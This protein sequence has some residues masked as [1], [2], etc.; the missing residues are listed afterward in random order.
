[1]NRKFLAVAVAT[2]S[3]SGIAAEWQVDV[4]TGND[5]AAAVDNTGATRFK[6]IQAA[7][8]KA[9]E[10]DVVRVHPGVYDSG[11]CVSRVEDGG[12][13][14]LSNRVWI[15]KKIT[16]V[17]VAGRDKTFI[18]GHHDPNGWNGMGPASVRCIGLG[19]NAEGTVV[20]GFTLKDGAT[21]LHSSEGKARAG[22]GVY[23]YKDYARGNWFVDCSFE[24]CRAVQGAAMYNCTAVRTYFR[25][26]WVGCN[27]SGPWV[28]GG[29]TRG[30]SHYF[31]VFTGNGGEGLLAYHS[32]VR[33]CTFFGNSAR[34]FHANN[35]TD[36]VY[37]CVVEGP[38]A[39][40]GSSL[41]YYSCAT[42]FAALPG[43]QTDT[44]KGEVGLLL[45]PISG[46]GRLVSSSK[47]L[48]IAKPEYL[49]GVITN[50]DYYSKDIDGNLVDMT[51]GKLH[52]GAY[53]K[54]LTPQGGLTILRSTDS[55]TLSI[56]DGVHRKSCT[57]YV[58]ASIFPTQFIVKA[59]VVTKSN[60]DILGIEST[61]DGE[62]K[63]NLNLPIDVDDTCI[64]TAPPAGHTNSFRALMSFTSYIDCDSKVAG[65]PDGSAAAPYRSFKEAIEA[66][67]STA[68]STRVF[69]VKPGLYANDTMTDATLGYRAR[70]SV[71][72]GVIARFIAEEGP[73]RT[74]IAG[75]S[76]PDTVDT[77]DCGCGPK[78]V[79]VIAP[80]RDANGKTRGDM[81]FNGFTLTDGRTAGGKSSPA[82]SDK[83]KD[84]ISGALGRSITGNYG[85][86]NLTFVGC[87]IS[88]NVSPLTVAVAGH[89]SR[90]RMFGNR[91]LGVASSVEDKHKAVFRE[92]V[93][94]SCLITGNTSPSTTLAGGLH[95]HATL[96]AGKNIGAYDSS[97]TLF[98]SIIVVD[99]G[100]SSPFTFLHG[101]VIDGYSSSSG[102][103]R[104][105]ADPEFVDAA[106]GDF[107]LYGTS[108]AIG[109]GQTGDK[110]Y[111][112][113]YGDIEGRRLV[114][115]PDSGTAISG[116]RQDTVFAVSASS[117]GDR[118][119][120]PSG[121]VVPVDG[122]ATFEATDA[123]T[124]NFL[125]FAVDGVIV[126]KES[127][128]EYMA[129]DSGIK[130]EVKAVY[131]T[132]WYVDASDKGNDANSGIDAEHPKK[133]LAA[134]L[135]H[136]VSGDTVH[137]APGDYRE[138]IAVH[139]SPI[140]DSASTIGIAARAVVPSGVALVASGARDETF[141]R[142]SRATGDEVGSDAVRCVVLGENSLL[143][144]FTLVDGCT[145]DA[146]A[147]ADDR[148]AAGV[149]AKGRTPVIEDCIVTNCLAV[150]SAAGW[151]GTWRRCRI[152]GNKA[153]SLGSGIRA[154]DIY[155]CF[156]DNNDGN[157]LLTYVYD[158]RHC[159][160][161]PGNKNGNWET[162]CISTSYTDKYIYGCLFAMRLVADVEKKY[163]FSK[164][165]M[166]AGNN[167]SDKENKVLQN[168]MSDV[169]LS[170]LALDEKGAPLIGT[171]PAVDYPDTLSVS[172]WSDSTMSMFDVNGGQRVYNGKM[173]V[174]AVEADWRSVYAGLLSPSRKFSVKAADPDV[175]A[176]ED[177][178]LLS[179]CSICVRWE[180]VGEKVRE[181][182]ADVH[183][184]GTLSVSGNGLAIGT[185]AT[186]RHSAR[187]SAGQT[188]DEYLF[189]HEPTATGDASG[190]ALLYGFSRM[191]GS[192][193]LVR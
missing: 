39:D 17:S 75:E 103:A 86:A 101:C 91:T 186:G 80:V 61:Y 128:F 63:H 131:A 9:A 6:T 135:E 74:I 10:N 29:A 121:R 167:V 46:N 108:Q 120:S 51:P 155:G 142:G 166:P 180:G 185:Y 42:S 163:I 7:V 109:F 38:V 179:N 111:R 193:I 69:R 164:C 161:G 183:D 143:R 64:V 32:Q 160:F 52:P 62:R 191:I 169:E 4:A 53:Q 174:G 18:V 152:V 70:I 145:D 148:S 73:E 28:C 154:A 130:A 175:V 41:R 117:T 182:H 31:C 34:S 184:N 36:N 140:T 83:E 48:G 158:V 157:N 127:T 1:M 102:T 119:I 11:E 22:G 147:S 144:G 65:S 24:N 15:A 14:I 99:G 47:A 54:P 95:S 56:G 40:T 26:N 173:D 66:K 37:N 84:F 3:F 133:T 23:A 19:V 16:L 60:N 170:Q 30:S 132:D 98:N 50:P 58:W 8:D 106:G 81:L 187:L 43:Q 35:A 45:D 67:L 136:A 92:A 78:A 139:S 134:A 93:T 112:Y 149:L 138:K 12:E 76:D 178:V 137:A 156:F 100:Q 129:P 168:C 116:C 118:G 172:A 153:N 162:L 124:R 13:G 177:G 105:R 25:N 44:V 89:F 125:G 113:S 71:S 88:N 171:N 141:I 189:A 79:R 122:F 68:Y 33:N 104:L 27:F 96:I 151:G 82:G 192:R 77:E 97:T 87:I 90:C 94:S 59:A 176:T 123:N 126:S 159:T 110:W 115:F 2:V 114:L 5:V 146:N 57:N 55:A 165:V 190:G 188:A 72:G 20:Q 21:T 150:R 181:F 85:Y 49:T 107:R